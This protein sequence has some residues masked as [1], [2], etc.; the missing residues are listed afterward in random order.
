MKLNPYPK[1][2]AMRTRPGR[3]FNVLAGAVLTAL[4]FA[5]NAWANGTAYYLDPNG[6]TTAG[7]GAAGSAYLQSNAQWNPNANGIGT[8]VAVPGTSPYYQM[9]FG[10]AGA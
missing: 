7:L 2:Q 4:C 3:S 6:G 10:N 1:L 5:Q 9:T 8:L